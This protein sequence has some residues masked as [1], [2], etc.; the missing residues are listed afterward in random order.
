M[1][2]TQNLMKSC[3]TKENVTFVKKTLAQ[4]EDDPHMPTILQFID[5]KEWNIWCL[6]AMLAK[7]YMPKRYLEIG[8]R[9]GFSMAMIVARGQTNHITGFDM[10]VKG[11]GGAENPGPSFVISEMNKF[12]NEQFLDAL[13]SDTKFIADW[14]GKN[15]A[16][17]KIELI[18]GDTAQTLPAY[19]P[20]A[21]F[22]LILVDGDHSYKGA[23]SNLENCLGILAKNGSIVIDDLQAESVLNACRT[24]HEKH[25]LIFQR[26]GRV[27]IIS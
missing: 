20:D 5:N 15:K 23:V 2:I 6:L 25:G 18:S 4:L 27:G 14:S 24:V 17:I 3:W 19:K 13:I 10:W 1:K 26:F 21:P 8:V 16:P 9:R 7:K 22:D 12:R 11:Y